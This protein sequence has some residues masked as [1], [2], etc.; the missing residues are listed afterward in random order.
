M[1]YTLVNFLLTIDNEIKTT[2]LWRGSNKAI[3][4]IE[5]NVQKFKVY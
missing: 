3:D 5:Y 1:T 4:V 2:L